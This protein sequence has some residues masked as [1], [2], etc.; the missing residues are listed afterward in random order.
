MYCASS[1]GLWVDQLEQELAHPPK[2]TAYRVL[3]KEGVSR[4]GVPQLVGT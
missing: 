1:V 2:L 4:S 3:L